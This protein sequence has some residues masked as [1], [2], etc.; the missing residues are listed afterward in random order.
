MS[1]IRYNKEA[2]ALMIELSREPIDHAEET[3]PFIIHFSRD[4]H[5]VLL[6][7][8]DAKDFVLGSLSSVVKGTEATLP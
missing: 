3:G 4:G 6:E 8:L 5:P 2:D 7:I 1:K